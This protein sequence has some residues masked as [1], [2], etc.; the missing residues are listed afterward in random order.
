MSA[1]TYRLTPST[2]LMMLI[3]PLLWAGN[4]VIG[5]MAAGWIPP[6]TFNF[7][8]WALA[9]L[10]LLP[11]AGS[12]LCPNSPMW[13]HWRRY[14]AL[15]MLAITTYNSL[16]YLALQTSS[17]V[18]VTLVAA[19]M[20]VWMLLVGRIGYGVTMTR[21][22]W[23]GALLS[24]LGVVVVLTQGQPLKLLELDLVAGDAW[25]LLAA[26]SWACYSWLLTKPDPC[27]AIRNNWAAFLLAQMVFGLL[28]SGL[29]MMGEWLWQTPHTTEATPLVA[30]GW[31]LVSVLV[32]VA[33][34]PAVLAYRF[35]GV[36][37]QRVGPTLAS[38]FAN[39]TPLFAAIL[40]SLF[41]GELPQLYHGMAF[42]LLVS[43][44]AVSAR[45]T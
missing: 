22:A 45:K 24:V 3:P 10:V 19:S 16:L 13:Q 1:P 7:L 5:R 30:W 35:W 36:G 15:G 34:G 2:A 25:M 8:R 14:A 31:P 20:P 40:S 28:V 21:Q 39:L 32:F 6:F 4:A 33:I 41:L 29:L 11:L 12:V 23:L 43:G 27:P 18:N 42:A 38:F 37:V 17:P 44:I 9:L 26:L